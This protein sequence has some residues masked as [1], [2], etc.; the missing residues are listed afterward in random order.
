VN[1][2]TADRPTLYTELVDVP[3]DAI[4]GKPASELTAVVDTWA[5]Y[6]IEEGRGGLKYGN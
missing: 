5:M 3:A 4:L 2:T 6:A 1:F